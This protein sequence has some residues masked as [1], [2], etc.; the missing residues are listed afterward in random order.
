MPAIS[1]ITPLYNT[2]KEVLARTWASLKAQTFTDW[3]WVIIDDSTRPETW[4]HLYGLAADERYKI[5]AYKPL[6]H[7]GS[8]GANK[9][10]GFSL[11]RGEYL[12]E[13]DHDDEL[14]PNALERIYSVFQNSS[15]TG[16][17]WSDWC[18]ILPDG[19][20][21]KY[22]DGWGQGLGVSYWDETL[23][24]WGL[25]IPV[26]TKD[27]LS[28]IVSVPNHVRAWRASTYQNVGGH[29]PTLTVADDYELIIRTAIVATSW[30]HIPQ[31]LYK[32][33]VN[34]ASAQRVN[35]A[36]IQERVAQIYQTWKPL[37]EAEWAHV[38]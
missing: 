21:G 9:L 10:D 20:S 32:Q 25:S 14:I 38:G 37:I 12:V 33:H 24:V 15:A 22:P 30:Q 11:A 27:S 18:E 19:Q 36:E 23:G 5:R 29:T 31:V 35:N 13:L 16:F 7:S 8:I 2:P 4:A 3:E 1:V 34:P 26:I 17:V 28:H 6:S